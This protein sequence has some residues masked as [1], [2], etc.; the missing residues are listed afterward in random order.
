V[1]FSKPVITNYQT[2]TNNPPIYTDTLA[3]GKTNQLE[4]R[5]D[6]FDVS[7]TRT[8]KDADG[9][10]IHFDTFVSDYARVNGQLEIGGPAPGQGTAPPPTPT[11]TTPPSE[12]PTAT[13]S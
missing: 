6:G 3:P 9:N 8:V 13:P 12:A 11:A 10:V 4:Y 5:T 7:V 2:A 1:T